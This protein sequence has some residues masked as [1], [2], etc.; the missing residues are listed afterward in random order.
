MNFP[1]NS[2]PFLLRGRC[3]LF[4]EAIVGRAAGLSKTFPV[5]F[6]QLSPAFKGFSIGACGVSAREVSMRIMLSGRT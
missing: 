6:S 2:L 4:K 5:W 1:S 3:S